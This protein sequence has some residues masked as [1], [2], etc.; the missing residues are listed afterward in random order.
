MNKDYIKVVG[1]VFIKDGKILISMSQRSAKSGK[2]TLVG[3]GVEP[4]ESIVEAAKRECEEEIAQGFTIETDELQEV[5]C[6]REPALSDPKLNIEM[7][8]FKSLKEIDV[9]LVPNEEILNYHW[10][11]FGDNINCLSSALSEHVIPWAMENNLL[12]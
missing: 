6:F 11:T 8:I 10:Y 12:S 4:Y 5:F 7:H 1:T 3:G 2:Y 9:P